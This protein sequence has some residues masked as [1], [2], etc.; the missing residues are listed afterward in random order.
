MEILS[1]I[2]VAYESGLYCMGYH[3][4]KNRSMA[5]QQSIS[6]GAIHW[7]TTPWG[8]L[9]LCC[10]SLRLLVHLRMLKSLFPKDQQT[11]M[12]QCLFCHRHRSLLGCADHRTRPCIH[13][14]TFGLLGITFV[15]LQA[16]KF[17][18]HLSYL[19]AAWAVALI[20]MAFVNGILTGNPVLIYDNAENLGIR[21]GTIPLEDFFYNLLYMTWMISLYEW[22]KIREY[23]KIRQIN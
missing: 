7:R 13:L 9:V 20:P 2:D 4:H 15:T 10:G 17:T 16:I 11:E 1:F 3:R 18:H 14:S 21:I 8:I 22:Y 23:R 6:I 19:M 5:V 12:A